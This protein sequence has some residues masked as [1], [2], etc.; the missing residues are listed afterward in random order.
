MFYTSKILWD[1]MEEDL[2]EM[3]QYK[4]LYYLAYL[5]VQHYNPGRPQ[6]LILLNLEAQMDLKQ[7]FE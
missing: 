3:W 1:K 7:N 4:N 5:Q 6:R 2:K